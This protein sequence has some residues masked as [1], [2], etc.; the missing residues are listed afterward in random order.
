MQFGGS[1]EEISCE[2]APD[3]LF[4]HERHAFAPTRD[5]QAVLKKEKQ[6]RGATNHKT[7]SLARGLS[8]LDLP[9]GD[10]EEDAIEA[11]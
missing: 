3:R 4:M 10:E 1:D 2:D 7:M 6:L 9:R 5:L 8:I 11:C